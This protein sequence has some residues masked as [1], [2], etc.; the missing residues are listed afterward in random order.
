[1]EVRNLWKVRNWILKERLIYVIHVFNLISLTQI[2]V[3]V[4]CNKDKLSNGA[5][6]FTV[7]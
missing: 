5:M 1:M 2:F 3:T 7:C 4:L 6:I